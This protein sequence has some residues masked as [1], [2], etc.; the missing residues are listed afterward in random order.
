MVVEMFLALII[1]LFF[2]VLLVTVGGLE[3]PGRTGGGP[4]V[5]FFFVLLFVLTWTGG[6]WMIPFGPTIWE[7]YWFPFLIVGFAVA[8]LIAAL[9]PR[10]RPR[11]PREVQEAAREQVEAEGA[12]S[13]FFWV[14]IAFV[15]LSLILHYW[16]PMAGA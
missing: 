6:V 12:I 10:R 15:A 4:A 3:R 16:S 2:S 5:F 11:T 13:M 9:I 7:V 8:L 14:L 1:A